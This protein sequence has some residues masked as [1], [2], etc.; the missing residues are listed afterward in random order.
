MLSVQLPAEVGA[1]RAG[2]YESGTT[3]LGEAAEAQPGGVGAEGGLGPLVIIGQK[4]G[5]LFEAAADRR[6]ERRQQL[7]TATS[8]L[9]SSR[10]NKDGLLHRS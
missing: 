1:R 3:V 7:R 2:S 8:S 4:T 9:R 10:L 5:E 6:V